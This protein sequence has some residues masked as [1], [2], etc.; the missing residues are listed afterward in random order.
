V[1]KR[2]QARWSDLLLRGIPDVS[3][4][5][6]GLYRIMFAGLL[7]VGVAIKRLPLEPFPQELHNHAG[8]VADW[9]VFHWLASRPDLVTHLE[10]GLLVALL[11]FG[12]GF[13]TRLSLAVVA[14]STL[15]WILVRLKHSGVHDWAILLPAVI[16]ILPVRWG[17]AFSVDE[18]I[19]RW[20]G[21]GT[22]GQPHGRHYGFGIW[23][24]GFVLGQGFAAAALAKLRQ[25]GIG[26]ILSGAVRYHFVTDARN[27]PFNWGLWV[28]S[29]QW[30]AIAMSFMAIWMEGTIILGSFV[31]RPAVRMVFACEAL[32]V[33]SGFYVFQNEFWIAWWILT[34]GLLPWGEIFDGLASRLPSLVTLV[35][36]QC[37]LC[38][39]IARVINGL[40]WFNRITFLNVNDPAVRVLFAPS[41][42]VDHLLRDMHVV[43]RG[44][45]RI[46]TGYRGY[47][48][49][50][51]AIPLMW[52][53]V[54]FGI[55]PPIASLGDR[56]YR[57]VARTRLRH[58]PCD[59]ASCGAGAEPQH[60]LPAAS[61]TRT[62]GA[63]RVPSLR[64]AQLVVIGS[65]CLLQATASVLRVEFEPWMS[66]Y[67]MY[68]GTYAS[69][70]E[71][72]RLN[73]IKRVYHF[74][75]DPDVGIPEDI[76]KAMDDIPEADVVVIAAVS[77][78]VEK[79]SLP[80]EQKERVR[81]VA[82]KFEK[83]MARPLGRVTLLVDEEAFNWKRGRFYWKKVGARIGTL[84]TDALTLL[85][86]GDE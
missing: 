81:A 53:L 40:D 78:L 60:V 46:G 18:T 19:R 64:P 22:A 44:S 49:L 58:A 35:D 62:A 84:D 41:T 24:P 67:P 74:R 59:D 65:V 66:D 4:E 28:A 76:S 33:L 11:L 23:L 31:R 3:A 52:P 20:R 39:R 75:R 47:L 79:G 73:P 68:A 56:L 16:G 85:R 27:A 63:A 36:D 38:R 45:K 13:L 1:T 77:S 5:A 9:Q 15:T 48:A 26:W 14:A 10:Q 71:F 70:E 54:A 12:I 69:T 29:H 30:V 42:P 61:M 50:A 32:L 86:S 17:D 57:R 43:D 7:I 83:Q 72:D 34:I 37:P 82:E 25:S 51:R 55:L 6:L 21:R 2:S 8:G 80:P